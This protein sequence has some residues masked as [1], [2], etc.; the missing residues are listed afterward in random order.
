M[1]AELGLM[2]PFS[3]GL[4]QEA[5]AGLDHHLHLSADELHLRFL[6]DL[7]IAY[8]PHMGNLAHSSVS[9]YDL[10]GE[11]DL[12]KAPEPIIEDQVFS[13]DPMTAAISMISGNEDVITT[14][15]IE[16]ADMQPMQHEVL[17]S[18]VFYGC[19]DFLSNAA[20]E[21][22]LSE[23]SNFSMCS[24]VMENPQVVD[25]NSAL[26]EIPRQ[27]SVSSGCLNS[28]EWIN[29]CPMRPSFLDF[30]GLDFGGAFGMRRSYSEGD[31]QTL[32]SKI[33]F[34]GT[35]SIV[36]SSLTIGDVN[37]NGKIEERR[38]KL[39]RY[40]RKK[41]KRNFGRKIKYACRKALADSQPRVRGRFAKTE[42]CDASKPLK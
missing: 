17:L 24:L 15:T 2:L 11:G 31:I 6:A 19:K 18:E 8:V 16:G 30:Q 12:F 36:N 25:G 21:N 40:R 9:E 7:S 39:S 32:G 10:G 5:H 27:K 20:I 42:E 1:F 41:S 28:G 22:S 13:L 14:E 26:H 37:L 35:S 4:P 38:E 34:S 3:Q 33:T 23:V 29:N